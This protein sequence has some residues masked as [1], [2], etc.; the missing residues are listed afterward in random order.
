[1]TPPLRFGSVD[2]S[3]KALEPRFDESCPHLVM[4]A[5]PKIEKK[6]RDVGIMCQA[7]VAV[8]KGRSYALDLHRAI[9]I[10]GCRDGAGMR[11]ESD[12]HCVGAE[13]LA[14]ELADV[15]LVPHQTHFSERG[16]SDMRIVGPNNRFYIL[17]FGCHHVHERV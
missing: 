5:F 3:D 9:P 11:P 13:L 6:A 10:A 4:L 8:G 16:V 15:Q 2:H 14:A 17:V 1:M 7:F 12:E